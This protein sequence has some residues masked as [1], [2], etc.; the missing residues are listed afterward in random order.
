MVI[1]ECD[2]V[3]GA[4]LESEKSFLIGNVYD[5]RIWS[6]ALFAREVGVGSK[7]RTRSHCAR[8]LFECKNCCC[9]EYPN[10]IEQVSVAL[11]SMSLRPVKDKEVN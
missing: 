8:S 7:V 9:I 4:S 2:L 3:V 1:E 5:I 10:E 6:K 11:K